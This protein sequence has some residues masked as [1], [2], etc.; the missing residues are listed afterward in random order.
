MLLG[1]RL[2]RS[3]DKINGHTPCHSAPA[4]G[5]VARSELLGEGSAH[6]LNSSGAPSELGRHHARLCDDLK[7][8]PG[9]WYEGIEALHDDRLFDLATVEFKQMRSQCS[10]GAVYV[11]RLTRGVQHGRE[12]SHCELFFDGL[13][14]LKHV[15]GSIMEWR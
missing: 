11:P 4:T 10:G 12:L 6:H 14:T 9:G 15:G 5:I 2:E 8:W 13:E 1:E 7:E 3:G